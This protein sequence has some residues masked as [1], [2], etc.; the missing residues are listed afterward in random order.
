MAYKLQIVKRNKSWRAGL[1]D[2][3]GLGTVHGL[4]GPR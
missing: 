1:G 3:T 2:I 4:T